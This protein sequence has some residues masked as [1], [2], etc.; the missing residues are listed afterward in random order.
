MRL[1]G[2]VAIVT[3]A[4]AGIGRAIALRLAR[5]GA[6]VIIAE[7][8]DDRGLEAESECVD[9]T[10]RGRFIRTDVASEADVDSMVAATLDI[11]GRLDV[12]VNN[13]GVN[14]VKPTRETTLEDWERVISVDL[15]GVFLCSR[16]ALR[17]MVPRKSGCIVNISSV[18][19]V[20]T[21]PA[22]APYAAAK[23]GVSA[24]TRS[25]A[26]EFGPAG[27][28]V[29]AVCPG[30]TSTEIWKDLINGAPNP[31]RLTNHW[32]ANIPLKRV[33][34]PSEVAG[35]V[36]FLASEDASYITGAEIYTDGGMTAM[37][38]HDESA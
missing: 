21:L 28:R 8:D 27:V 38:A 20:Q 33:Q 7:V 16:A 3:G 30:L 25:M 31:D 19:A 22:A 35:V 29:N 9:A 12:L 5:D 23:G 36:A 17:T 6:D 2:R 34:E 4:G 1:D 32:L 11:Y 18:H 37:L 14:F 15:R 24:M 10:G 13:A 26:I